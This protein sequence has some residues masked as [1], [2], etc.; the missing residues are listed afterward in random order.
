L[1]AWGWLDERYFPLLVVLGMASFFSAS[2][3]TPLTAAVFSIEVFSGLG[4]ILPIFVAI[5]ISYV[6]VETVGVV[7]INEIAMEREL[8]R[9]HKGKSRLTVDVSLTVKPGCFA[10][11]KEPRDILW[12]PFCHVL[13]V[14]KGEAEK[15]SYEGGIIREG[16]ILRLNFTTYDA[17]ATADELCAIL[18]EQDVY[19][20]AEVKQGVIGYRLTESATKNRT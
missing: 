18:G 10:I 13:S 19:A 6:I 17:D 14:R 12:P 5:L 9:A 15:D 1:I 11:D 20:E 4:N 7:S 2:V 8:H 16:D 3:R